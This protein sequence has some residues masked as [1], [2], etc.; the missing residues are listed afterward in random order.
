MS[1]IITM[2][3]VAAFALA[4]L[5]APV[6]AETHDFYRGKTIRIIVGA[7]PG[8][9]FDAYARVTARHMVK[10][11]PGNPSFIVQNMPGA[12]GLIAANYTYSL[13][14]PDGLTISHFAGGLFLQQLLGLPE[15]KFD[16]RNF[17]HI[18]VPV[19]DHRVLV[20]AKATGVT[21]VEK[22]MA[23]E[24]PVILGGA[25]PGG[26]LDDIPKILKATLGL[27]I[28]LVTG[29]SGTNP[30]RVAFH[31]GEVQGA[32]LA[33]EVV[34]STW[35]EELDGGQIVIVLQTATRA[36][37]ELPGIPVVINLVKTEDDKKLMRAALEPH[38]PIYRPFVAPPGVPQE[39]LQVL[40]KSF[41][42]TMRDGQFLA[43]ARKARLD[44]NP[45]DGE[46]LQQ[47]VGEIFRLEPAL[48]EK[49]K[50]ILK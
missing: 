12:G 42:E 44:I 47:I 39:R 7:A 35:R 48:V 43:E 29:Y 16:A 15:V 32:V 13:A 19:R 34:Q 1:S 23:S 21:D 45:L 17:G 33:W 40:R 38:G 10:H 49:L 8:G 14:K 28:R 6:I 5:T 50:G 9:G 2:L 4:S 24:K 3:T 25:S 18:G 27:P 37:P 11:T 31:R 20:L 22:L 41:M 46:D 26:A 36:H 30:I